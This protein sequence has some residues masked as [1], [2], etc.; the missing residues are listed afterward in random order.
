MTDIL[1][2]LFENDEIICINKKAGIP[3]QPDLTGDF[4]AFDEV[5][6]YLKYEPFIL[7]RIDRPVSGIVLF[8]KDKTAAKVYSGFISSGKILKIYYAIVENKPDK[9]EGILENYLTKKGKKTYISRESN[10]GKKAILSYKY[11]GSGDRY[12]YLKISLKTGRFHQIRAQLANIGCYIKGDVKYGAKRAN[13]DRSICLHAHEINFNIDNK[14][15]KITAN[16]P[17]SVLWEDIQRVL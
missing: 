15:L 3:S 6:S 17:K 5:K 7:N 1:E 8:A 2:I 13:K 4:S 14:L 16:F 10:K 9:N 11:I 12:H